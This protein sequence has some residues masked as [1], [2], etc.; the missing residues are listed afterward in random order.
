MKSFVVINKSGILAEIINL[1]ADSEGEIVNSDELR[2]AT[3]E[4]VDR[5]FSVVVRDNEPDFVGIRL[6]D[7]ET[8]AVLPYEVFKNSE[9]EVMGEL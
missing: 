4:P 8:Y 6:K 3:D 1:Y 2:E 9:C 7:Y 5:K